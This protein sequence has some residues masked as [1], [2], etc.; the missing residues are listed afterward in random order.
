MQCMQDWNE[1][2]QEELAAE[3]LDELQRQ[4]DVLTTMMERAKENNTMEGTWNSAE[5]CF[6]SDKGRIHTERHMNVAEGRG[7]T[8]AWVSGKHEMNVT[9]CV[10][11]ISK[12]CAWE[13]QAHYINLP[14]DIMTGR[15]SSFMKFFKCSCCTLSIFLKD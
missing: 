11:E 14:A 6:C 5:A 9:R 15:S 10:L 3:H 12:K 1:V 13:G 2:F 7:K 8:C 4:M